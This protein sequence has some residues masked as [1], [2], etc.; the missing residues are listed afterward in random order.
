MCVLAAL[1]FQDIGVFEVGLLVF[2]GRMDTLA[3]HILPCD[4]AMAEL[5]LSDRISLLKRR[6]EPIR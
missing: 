1:V 5:S 2:L 3:R 6:L 4:A